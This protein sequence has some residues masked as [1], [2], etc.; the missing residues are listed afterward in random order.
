MNSY[1][2]IENGGGFFTNTTFYNFVE[3]FIVA[4]AIS[5]CAHCDRVKNLATRTYRLDRNSR[6]RCRGSGEKTA[7]NI[8]NGQI[9]RYWYNVAVISIDTTAVS[10]SHEVLANPCACADCKQSFHRVKSSE[11]SHGIVELKIATE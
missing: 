5:R 2:T 8:E 11:T 3:A 1:D 9:S 7:I 10:R 4:V 6:K